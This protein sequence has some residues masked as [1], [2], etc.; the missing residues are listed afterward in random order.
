MKE[1][2]ARRAGVIRQSVDCDRASSRLLE[3]VDTLDTVPCMEGG[4]S[5]AERLAGLARHGEHI[6][7]DV[8][9]CC[10][11]FSCVSCTNIYSN[12]VAAAEAGGAV[13]YANRAIV[14]V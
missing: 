14:R 2:D 11:C 3:Q 7:C 8:V 6:A 13:S 9:V 5:A 1:A 12:T 4:E 10:D